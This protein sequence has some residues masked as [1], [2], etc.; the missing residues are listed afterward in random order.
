MWFMDGIDLVS[1]TLMNPIQPGSEWKVVGT[2]D[3]NVDGVVDIAFQHDNGTLAV[4]NMNGVDLTSATLVTP[5]DPGSLDWRVVSVADRNQDGQPDLLFQNLADGTLA[6][7]HMDG[8]TLRSA[9][10]LNP[11]SPGGTWKVVAPK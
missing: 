4:W 11:P 1:A 10:L 7:W 3:F 8:V 2:G 6:I 9:Q 5:S